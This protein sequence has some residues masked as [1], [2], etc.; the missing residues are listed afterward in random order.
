MELRHVESAAPTAQLIGPNKTL[1]AND[2]LNTIKSGSVV[3]IYHILVE[4][5]EFAGVCPGH[6]HVQTSNRDRRLV[7]FPTRN[8]KVSVLAEKIEKALTNVCNSPPTELRLV[9]S[10]APMVHANEILS[11]DALK[12]IESGSVIGITSLQPEDGCSSS[13]GSS[14]DST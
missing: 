11:D 10:A 3:E 6:V 4:V 1:S 9:E 5:P 12:T 14:T 7:I 8:I 13:E 2:T